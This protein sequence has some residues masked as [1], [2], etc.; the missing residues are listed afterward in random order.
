MISTLLIEVPKL[1]KFKTLSYLFTIQSLALISLLLVDDSL[2]CFVV[3]WFIW[4]FIWSFLY[5]HIMYY[6]QDHFSKKLYLETPTFMNILWP[7]GGLVF[8]GATFTNGNWVNH[9][10][11]MT[12][13]PILLATGIFYTVT[14]RHHFSSEDKQELDI[15]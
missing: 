5:S 12:G 11:Y 10:V 8:V 3:I 2:S 9:C 7:V 15:N 6:V 13:V 1:Q 4:N 14:P